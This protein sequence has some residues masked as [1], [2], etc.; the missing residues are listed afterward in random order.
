[1]KVEKGLDLELRI[2]SELAVAGW[3]VLNRVELREEDALFTD[4]DVLG[5]KMLGEQERWLLVSSKAGGDGVYKTALH[6]LGT[7]VYVS[8]KFRGKGV[9]VRGLLVHRNPPSKF[10]NRRIIFRNADLFRGGNFLHKH[11]RR[12]FLTEYYLLREFDTLKEEVRGLMPCR[13][14]NV[15]PECLNCDRECPVRY[16]VLARAIHRELVGRLLWFDPEDRLRTILDISMM[17][18][19]RK[20]R[21]NVANE[22][23][24]AGV[25]DPDHHPVTQAAS[26]LQYRL[27][28]FSLL[29]LSEILAGRVDISLDR[30]L[31]NRLPSPEL[32]RIMPR[33]FQVFLMSWGGF[34]WEEE[35]ERE[36][37]AIA[38]EIG[39]E[40]EKFRE[41][42]GAF[43]TIFRSKME[44][45]S[46]F[47]LVA[48]KSTKMIF[49]YPRIMRGLGVLRREQFYGD[50]TSFPEDWE[51]WKNDHVSFIDSHIQKLQPVKNEDFSHGNV[52]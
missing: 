30:W 5:I 33:A 14:D 13:N 35:R 12:A 34:I 46:W 9:A 42:L 24:G 28:V 23:K 6:L 7:V 15:K 16:R 11:W 8:D 18:E 26:Y 39:I 17:E 3:F 2:A 19:V 43:E 32:L 31:L 51:L 20:L 44:D 36:I 27:K 41:C 4:I 49:L 38:G 52:R 47:Q 48:N 1:M 25:D 45:F 22:L 29:T 40:P 50:S 10:D 37:K 21:N